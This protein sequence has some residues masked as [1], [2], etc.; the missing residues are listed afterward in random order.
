MLAGII[1]LLIS[2]GIV[3]HFFV[4]SR[5]LPLALVFDAFTLLIIAVLVIRDRRRRRNP[6]TSS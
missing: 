4:S 5:S 2:E 1:V 6:Q 3:I